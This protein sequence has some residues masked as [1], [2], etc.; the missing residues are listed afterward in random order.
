[1]LK[2]RAE[3][4]EMPSAFPRG[5]AAP[6]PILTGSAH[7]RDDFEVGCFSTPITPDR[8]WCYSGNPYHPEKRLCRFSKAPLCKP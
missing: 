3:P 7:R 4:A 1:M 5:T 8:I 6:E 2:Y